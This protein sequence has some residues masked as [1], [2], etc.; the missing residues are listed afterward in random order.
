MHRPRHPGIESDQSIGINRWAVS[1][2]V[3]NRSPR[4][5]SLWLQQQ[6]FFAQFVRRQNDIASIDA[7]FGKPG[8]WSR[9]SDT[10]QRPEGI[11]IRESTTHGGFSLLLGQQ[12]SL[13]IG[14]K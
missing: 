2:E 8:S 1:L 9:M 14:L 10:D 13:A 7:R 3:E 4:R 6:G 5:S 12:T 11:S